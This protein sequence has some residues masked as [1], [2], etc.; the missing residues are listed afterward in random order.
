MQGHSK[1]QSLQK[2]IMVNHRISQAK[3][4]CCEGQ[5]LKPKHHIISIFFSSE[6]AAD[7]I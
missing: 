2:R 5:H 7:L 6:E 4:N 1:S 3:Q